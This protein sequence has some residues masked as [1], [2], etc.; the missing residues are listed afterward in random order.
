MVE[1]CWIWKEVFG[2]LLRLFVLA[3]GCLFLLLF[4]FFCRVFS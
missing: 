1:I 4:V 2:A 3:S